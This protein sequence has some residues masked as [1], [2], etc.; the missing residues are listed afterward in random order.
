[1]ICTSLVLSGKTKTTNYSIYT[2]NNTAQTIKINGF[3]I[4]KW[5][6]VT[7]LHSRNSVVTQLSY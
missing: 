2:E 5:I 3:Q 1:M 4:R 7:L 6:T